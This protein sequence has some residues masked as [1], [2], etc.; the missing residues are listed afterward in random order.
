MTILF[1]Q[2]H[3]SKPIFK[4]VCSRYIIKE[5]GGKNGNSRFL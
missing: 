1:I 4:F 2:I 3:E 5:E